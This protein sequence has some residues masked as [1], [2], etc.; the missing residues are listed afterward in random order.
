MRS[1]SDDAVFEGVAGFEAE[2]ADGFHADV[3]VGGGVDDDGIRLVG[4]GAGENVDYAAARV[5]DADERNFDLLERAVEIE[6][7]AGELADAEFIVDLDQGVN[8]FAAG[9]GVFEAYARLK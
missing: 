2:D 1:G 6:A 5:G 7:E 4:D 9:A 8:F 3:L